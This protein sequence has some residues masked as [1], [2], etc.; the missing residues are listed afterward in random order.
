NGRFIK[1]NSGGPGRPRR[2]SEAEYI[3]ALVE[4]VSP[5]KWRKVVN[6]ALDDAAKGDH[7][8]RRFLAAYLMG[9]PPQILELHAG[10]AALLADL[11]KLVQE[12]GMP[13]SDILT[14]MIEQLKETRNGG[15]S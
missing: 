9:K 15:G 2:H 6:K 11:V 7:H 1:G 4:Q 13:L 3:E 5:T 14:A 10:D 8:A 12:S